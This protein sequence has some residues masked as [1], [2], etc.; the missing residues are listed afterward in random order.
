MATADIIDELAGVADNDRMK[1]LRDQRPKARVNAQ[2]S[3]EALFEPSPP[4]GVILQERNVIAVFV[5]GLHR[6]APALAHYQ[7][8]LGATGVL[9]SV[10][11]EEI[12]RGAAAGPYG[13]YPEGPLSTENREGPSYQVSTSNRD[14]LGARLPAAL[15]HAHLLVFHP[16]DADPRALKAL[17]DA[18]WSTTDVVTLSRSSRS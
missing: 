7:R 10:L 18:G 4:R 3:Y 17:R 2:K 11:D 16:R 5:A 14:A 6:D 8:A 15:E 13:R 9:A 12:A 1:A